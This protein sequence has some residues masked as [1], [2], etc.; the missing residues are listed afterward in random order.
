MISADLTKPW[1]QASMPARVLFMLGLMITLLVAAV[2]GLFFVIGL[3][4]GSVTFWNAGEWAVLLVVSFGVPAAGLLLRAHG[5]TWLAVTLMA[6]LAIPSVLVG[7][8]V[9]VFV[10]SG[11]RWQ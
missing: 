11:A 3:I 9:L 2:A 1:P 7:L 8:A 10:L 5:H 4:D 6:L